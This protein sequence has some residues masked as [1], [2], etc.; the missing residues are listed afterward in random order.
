MADVRPKRAAAGAN[1][2]EMISSLLRTSTPDAPKRSTKHDV[3]GK[4]ATPLASPASHTSTASD[5]EAECAKLEADMKRLQLETKRATL[6]EE[7]RHL[8]QGLVE[9][10]R[11]ARSVGGEGHSVEAL[12]GEGHAVQ[13][14]GAH[15]IL[16][17]DDSGSIDL[18]KKRIKM[19]KISDYMWTDSLEIVDSLRKTVDLG[20][21]IKL[22]IGNM[23]GSLS[24]VSQEMWTYASIGIMRE[25]IADKELDTGGVGDYLKYMQ[26]VARLSSKYVW[27]SVL[28]Y[29]HEYRM[30]QA[31][32]GFRWGT[33][34]QDIRDFQLIPKPYSNTAKALRQMDPQGHQPVAR[35]NP[36][37]R[38]PFT[39]E[40]TEICRRFNYGNC[41]REEL[42]KLA[43]VCLLCHKQGHS[44]QQHDSSSVRGGAQHYNPQ[45]DARSREY[46]AK[47]WSAPTQNR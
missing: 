31:D 2:P 35:N 39:N 10:R 25:L 45:P 34:L 23:K 3:S 1:M 36:R 4:M 27:G 37:S 5:L 41:T 6:Q 32:E 26:D 33:P 13:N 21:G 43:H 12:E 14:G 20:G 19:R 9:I 22:D 40:G 47:N 8:E 11:R 24:K 7:V 30:K 15:V 18:G 38:G 29:D 42:C 46:E 16:G 17:R 28:L 44:R